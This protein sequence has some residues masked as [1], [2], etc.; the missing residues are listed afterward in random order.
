M[1][2]LV[3][4]DLQLA[5]CQ[6]K[7]TKD[8]WRLSGVPDSW[9]PVFVLGGWDRGPGRTRE[10]SKA[11]WTPLN[12]ISLSTSFRHLLWI[13]GLN[14]T[15]VGESLV[16][17]CC[18][19]Q[20]MFQ[21]D[22]SR[23]VN[24]PHSPSNR[25]ARGLRVLVGIAFAASWRH[26]RTLK[27]TDGLSWFVDLCLNTHVILHYS[28]LFI[29]ILHYSTELARPKKQRTRMRGLKKCRGLQIDRNGLWL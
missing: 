2:I 20:E 6:G 11:L 3:S 29:T 1:F 18:S 16:A 24:G 25:Q 9:A 12:K 4:V 8:S 10:L 7:Q 14:S 17:R 13:G 15:W 5:G 23:L 21:N 19:P 27:N 22:P 26:W 28:T